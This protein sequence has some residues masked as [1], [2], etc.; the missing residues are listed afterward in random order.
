M[1]ASGS[2]E[3]GR[4][5]ASREAR[6]AK[7]FAAG[8]AISDG[9]SGQVTQPTT[10]RSKGVAYTH[11]AWLACNRDWFYHYPPVEPGDK[12][13]R[14]GPISHGSGYLFVPI[15]L[16][17]G[18]NVMVDKFEPSAV[19]EIMEREGIA[20]LFAVPTMVNVLN[21]EPTVNSGSCTRHP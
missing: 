6:I 14:L 7:Q 9:I 1:S 11:K 13:L 16:G 4:L 18:C 2:G 21:H 19:V 20:Y 12:C 5:E 10:G 15:W 3:H 17:G 8:C